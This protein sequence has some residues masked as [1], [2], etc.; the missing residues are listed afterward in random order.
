MRRG[1]DGDDAQGMTTLAAS[2][3]TARGA[4]SVP[5]RRTLVGISVAILLALVAVL[6]TGGADNEPDS[7][8]STVKDSYDYS[9]LT[10]HVLSYS[11]M[12]LCALMVFLGVALRAA[13]RSQ[14]Q[15]HWAADAAMLGLTVVGLT[16]AGWAVSGLAMW[17]A[18]DQGEDAS[19]RTLNFLD[20]ASFL[21]LMMGMI[22]AYVGTGIAG[23][24][25]GALPKW[26]AVASIVLGCLA[27][28]GPLGFA[29]ATLLPLWVVVVSALVR[30][31]E[32][33]ALAP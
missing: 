11:G 7:S 33:E 17:H 16:V 23:L 32:G 12:V 24:N 5:S 27:P 25:S 28:L 31:G 26:L 8:L 21:P 6:A 15:Q 3:N 9:Q 30:L 14:R 13:L 22:C 4:S 10:L 20:T 19:I 18:V 1:S 29:P 2:S